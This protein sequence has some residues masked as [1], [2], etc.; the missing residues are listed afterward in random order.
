VTASR[1]IYMQKEIG[2]KINLLRIAKGLTL[3]ELSE[4]TNLSVSF[5]S[6]AE[7]GLTS[8]A[9]M[10]LRKIA[11]A[12]EKDLTFF[13]DTP[14]SH[15]DMI[16]RSHEQEII[17]IDESKFIHFNLGSEITNKRFDPILVNILPSKSKEEIIPYAHDG[18]EFIY[19]L[20]GICT[21]FINDRTYELYPGDS[22]HFPST[23]P[24]T[25]GNLTNKVVKILAINSPS[26]L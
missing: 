1:R 24:H 7:N 5:L 6:Q 4:K 16:V 19:I 14:K 12:L 10:S 13:F 3:K 8:I 17:R 26:V 11:E 22:T 25:W 2:E 9:I 23:I 20:E 21:V 18:E 15:R